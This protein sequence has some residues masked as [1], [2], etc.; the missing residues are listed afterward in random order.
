MKNPKTTIAGII[1]GSAMSVQPIIEN[2]DFD[3][4]RDWLKMVVSIGVFL[5]GVFA[6][7][8]KKQY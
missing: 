5:L 1:L 8:P 7:D 2:G 6:H 4:K 3:V